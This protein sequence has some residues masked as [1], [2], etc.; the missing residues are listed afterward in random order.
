MD[1]NPETVVRT[2][3]AVL[4]EPVLSWSAVIAGA[5]VALA[6]SILLTLLAAGFGYDLAFGGLPS[7]ASDNA[8]TPIVGAGAVVIQVISA[9]LGGY[10]AGRLR[11]PWTSSHA[12]EAHFRD[13]AQGLIM[14][15]LATVAG[16]VLGLT[17][18]GPYAASMAMLTTPPA[19]LSPAAVAASITPT[20]EQAARQ[21]HIAAQ[22]ALFTALGMLLSAFMAAVTARIG[23]LR[24]EEMH[25]RGVG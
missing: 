16:I 7:R 5:L 25:A 15:A 22:A 19:D 11:H 17:V 2:G 10:L 14:W 6:V 23:G 21:A 24:S 9:M 1:A 18:L 4:F 13:T 20:P 3:R 12:D 8:F